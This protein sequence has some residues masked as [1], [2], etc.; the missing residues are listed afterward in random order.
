MTLAARTFIY[1][2]IIPGILALGAMAAIVLPGDNLS[3]TRL[4]TGCG[5]MLVVQI[6]GSLVGGYI[7]GRQH[8]RRA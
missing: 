1:G 3:M 8:G 5:A 2:M 7:A 6:T 4:L